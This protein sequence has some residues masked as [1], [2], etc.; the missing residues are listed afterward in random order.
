ML[1]YVIAGL[2][3]VLASA[4]LGA[5]AGLLTV[6]RYLAHQSD[7]LASDEPTDPYV[8]AQIDR[9]AAA[10]AT[11]NGRPEAAGLMADKLHMLHRLGQRRRWRS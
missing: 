5:L 10:W 7:S 9:A 11:A 2:V 8:S 6:R 4:L 3:L 1:N